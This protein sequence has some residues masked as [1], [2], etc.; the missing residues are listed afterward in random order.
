MDDMKV[1]FE[2]VKCHRYVTIQKNKPAVLKIGIQR[3][4][5]K[6]EVSLDNL[7]ALKMKEKQI[8]EESDTIFTGRIKN[9]RDPSNE[10]LNWKISEHD[11]S[12]MLN[13]KEIYK[14]FQILGYNFR[15]VYLLYYSN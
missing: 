12:K 15:Y 5:G 4:D 11:Q 7:H 9:S 8:A 6:F 14:K 3:I 10:M 2:N 13:H 1:T